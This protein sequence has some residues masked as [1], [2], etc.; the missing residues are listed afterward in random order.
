M[1]H[2][3]K[4]NRSKKKKKG[5]RVFLLDNGGEREV[6]LWEN[7]SKRPEYKTFYEC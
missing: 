4:A 7:S 3:I 2:Y 6:G 1:V 5:K